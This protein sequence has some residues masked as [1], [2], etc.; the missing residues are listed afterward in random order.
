MTNIML[1][2]SK[3]GRWFNYAQKISVH[4]SI[5]EAFKAND[6]SKMTVSTFEGWKIYDPCETISQEFLEKAVAFE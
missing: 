2:P 3:K 5:L 1:K 4:P 6:H